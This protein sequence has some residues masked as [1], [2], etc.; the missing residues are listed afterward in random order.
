M[1][2]DLWRSPPSPASPAVTTARV[3]G[4]L[5]RLR[6]QASLLIETT[7]SRIEI[8]L[9]R[10]ETTLSRIETTLLLI[11]KMLSP[12]GGVRQHAE[13]HQ[14]VGVVGGTSRNAS[15]RSRGN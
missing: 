1:C 6:R 10:I 12:F 3:S 2:H 5:Q 14:I 7:L 4:G 15:C 9:S 11:E 13:L 8:T